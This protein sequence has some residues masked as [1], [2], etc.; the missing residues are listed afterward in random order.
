M[1]AKRTRN[2]K[3]A[4]AAGWWGDGLP[5]WERWPGATIQLESV[6]NADRRRWESP[7]SRYWFDKDAA[8]RAVDFF[9]GFL[10]HHIGE[11]AGQ[12]FELMD[13][14]K[15]LLTRPIFGWKRVSDG[16][17]RFRKVF[18]FLPKG[19]GK[20][21]WASGTAL[22]LTLCD[23][24]AGAEVYAVAGDKLQA[25]I[26]FDNSRVLVEQSDDLASR[27][28]VLR[29]SI[30]Y[31]Q[32]RSTLK[33]LSSDAK[34]K[35]G[36]RPH[37]VVFDE[38]HNQPNRD[39]YEALSKSM[40]K[41]RQPLLLLIS[42]AG[43][44]DEGICYEEYELAKKVLSGTIPNESCL[45]VIFEASDKDDWKEPETW[46]KANPAHGITVKHDAIAAECEDAIAEP[47]KRNDFLRFHLNRWVN[48]AVSWIP[49][50]SW[51][52][53]RGRLDDATLRELPVYAGL[54]MSQKYDLTAFVLVF[55][56]PIDGP[57]QDIEVVT[58]EDNE[59][60]RRT[61][62]LNYRIN[63][64]PFFWLPADTLLERVRQDR[65]PYDQWHA[66]GLLRVT[67]GNAIDYN[68]V[69]DDI[70]G[71]ISERFPR[72]RE[73]QIG[74]DPAFAT[75]ISWRLSKAG[76]QMVEI[77]Q[78]YQHMSEPAHILE[79]LIKARRVT[80]DGHR[81]LRWNVENVAIKTDDAGRI[82][83]VKPK[84]VAKRIDGVVATLMALSRSM[85]SDGMVPSDSVYNHRGVLF[86]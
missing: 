39:L 76:Y 62:S 86:V 61:L 25:R 42:H 45:P 60:T 9:P 33:V 85:L 18:A 27:C 77:P 19:A 54:D 52:A 55:P 28:E 17:R 75:D 46:R 84:K 37:G 81:L 36:F 43:D 1:T 11:F 30:Y 57:A 3:E 56:S 32:T 44:D 4:P 5:P 70:E 78:N 41:R 66:S 22:Y 59:P 40:V 63:V 38:F 82:R 2:G 15:L 12:P 8:D 29:D 16:T 14:Q 64:V 58:T 53:C 79:A 6:W 47:R 24:E 49:I 72:L 10:T 71:P 26:V 48:T 67:E 69:F 13:Y 35:H 65:V 83:P 7:D 68:A 74:F 21:P 31:A 73:A 34:T 50:D 51:D 23:Q 80:H 20:S